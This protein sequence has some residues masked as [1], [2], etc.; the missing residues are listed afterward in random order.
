MAEDFRQVVAIRVQACQPQQV[1]GG[2]VPALLD[3]VAAAIDSDGYLCVPRIS[4][5][6]LTSRVALTAVW[7]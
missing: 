4:S 3:L 6:A 1:R 7:P 5:A 2:Q